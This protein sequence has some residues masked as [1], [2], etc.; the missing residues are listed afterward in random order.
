[1][2]LLRQFAKRVPHKLNPLGTEAD[3]VPWEDVDM[4]DKLVLIH[5]LCEWQFGGIGRLR[6]MMSDEHELDWV[7]TCLPLCD[8]VSS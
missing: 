2:Y 4:I 8:F 1:M 6:T 7:R 3:P 5:H